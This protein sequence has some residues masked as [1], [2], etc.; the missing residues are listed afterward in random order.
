MDEHLK[1]LLTEYDLILINTSGG[2]DSSVA[3]WKVAK[4]AEAAGVKDRCLMVHATFPEEWPGTVEIVKKQA[5]QL[6]LPVVVVKRGEGL[7][8]Y[9]RRRGMWPSSQQRYCTSDFKRA[10]IDKVITARA[11]DP[12]RQVHVLNVMGIRSEESPARAKREWFHEDDRRTN[13]RRIVNE[14]LPIFDMK[15]P[16]VWAFI[17]ANDIPVHKAYALGMPR[18]SCM[19]CIFAP[20][21]ALVLAGRHNTDVL[22]EYVKVEKEIGHSFRDGFKIAEVLKAV[23][24]GE[25]AGKVV[26]WKM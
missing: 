11:T 12:E 4:M 24:Q 3:G 19:F 17:K 25:G 23:E 21:A 15:L 7:L 6:G 13:G 10:P 16:E 18:L 5:V 22:R 9:V 26:D 2:K 8:D 14:W 20:K 1:P